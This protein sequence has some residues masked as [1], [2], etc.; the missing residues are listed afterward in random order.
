MIH[1]LVGAILSMILITACATMEPPAGALR[2]DGPNLPPVG[3]S[4][5]FSLRTTGSFGS[6]NTPVTARVLGDRTWNDRKVRAFRFGKSR[7]DL[8]E[9]TTGAFV[10]V[11]NGD[12]PSQSFDP[13]PGFDWPIFVGKSWQRTYTFTDHI[14]GQTFNRV[15]EWSRVEAFEE[16]KTLAGTFKTFKIITERFTGSDTR[17][18]SPELGI[19]IKL[20]VERNG[21]D[22]RGAGTSVNE[23]V[24]HNI[25]R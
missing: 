10:A 17:W 21:N 13:P 3:A 25:R 9:I 1:S 6:V 20:H 15:Q 7:T 16:I 12:T 23:L 22:F 24:S 18:W 19:N 11:L 14:S 2:A 4:W 8:F 5:V